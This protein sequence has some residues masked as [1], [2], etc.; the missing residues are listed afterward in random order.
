MPRI[1]PLE[2]L[3]VANLPRPRYEGL[4][5]ANPAVPCTIGMDCVG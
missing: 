4:T 1:D 3:S 5:A 2:W